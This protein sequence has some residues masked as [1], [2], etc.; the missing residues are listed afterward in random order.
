MIPSLLQLCRPW[1]TVPVSLTYLLTV[2][3]ARGGAMSGRWSDDA[4][5]SVALAL[6]IAAAYVV[7]DIVDCDVDK[8]NAPWRPC[9]AQRVSTGAAAGLAIALA[10]TGLTMA[11]TCSVRFLIAV[12]VIGGAMFAYDLLSKRI[13]PAKQVM[14]AVLMTSYYPLAIVQASG[15]YGPRAASLAVFPIW[16]LV[17][18]WGYELLKDLRDRM[19][20]PPINGRPTSLQRNPEKWRRLAGT[21]IAAAAPILAL[22]VAFGC[23]WV[24]AVVAAI[25]IVLGVAAAFVPLRRA[26]VLVYMECLVAAMAAG[27]DVMLLG[28]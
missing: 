15:A 27:L 1:Y 28:V 12:S 4:I 2:Y 26:I 10:V 17:T 18:A 19:G 6:V 14:V 5:S 23:K 13:G 24:Y 8:I 20:D 22:P 16:L 21:A 3:Y 9:A 11:A 7:N 25:A